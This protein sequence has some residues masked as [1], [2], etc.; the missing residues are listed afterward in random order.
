ML[1]NFQAS[2]GSLCARMHCGQVHTANSVWIR[3]S[4]QHSAVMDSSAQLQAWDDLQR[5]VEIG[6]ELKVWSIQRDALECKHPTCLV[7]HPKRY[8]PDVAYLLI[9][10]KLLLHLANSQ[11]VAASS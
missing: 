1:G 4:H 10:H 3:N 9:S 7:Y 5:A 2:T 11:T 8:H 6:K